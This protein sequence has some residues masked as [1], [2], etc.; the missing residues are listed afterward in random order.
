MDAEANY[1]NR[2]LVPDYPRYLAAWR[3]AAAAF[4]QATPGARLGVPYGAGR[5]EKLDLF[6]GG[7]GAAALFLHGGYWQALGRED[8]S[9]LAAGLVARG[10][11][12][13]IPSHDHC[14]AV[15]LSHIVA[16]ARAAAILTFRMTGQ[17]LLAI[18]HSAGGHLAAMLLATDWRRIDPALPRD[19]VLAALPISGVFDLAPLVGTTPGRALPLP[20]ATL[21]SCSPRFLPAPGRP[22]HCLVGA[23]ESAGFRDQSREMAAAWGGT[24]EEAP[25]AH[26]FT[27]IDPLAEPDSPLVATALRLCHAGR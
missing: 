9:H 22:L 17:R 19:L 14:P 2:L 18:G 13:A 24:A 7:G 23:L 1:N 16:Q 26:H 3:V 10:L 11:D 6:P 12:V 21:A 5:R 8:F 25:G 27:V 4:R 20:P 15:T